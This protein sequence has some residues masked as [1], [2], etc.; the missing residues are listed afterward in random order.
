VA[1]IQTEDD[2]SQVRRNGWRQGSVVSPEL[3]SVLRRRGFSP[4]SD[5][6]IALVLSHDCDVVNGRF[7]KEPLV[8]LAW[9]TRIEKPDGRNTRGKNPRCLH[10]PLRQADGRELWWE[11]TAPC[12]FTEDRRLLL[13]SRPSADLTLPARD[14]RVVASWLAKRHDRS[15]FPDGFNRRL[16]TKG[17]KG[18][19]ETGSAYISELYLWGAD[20][21]LAEGEPYEILLCAVMTVEDFGDPEHRTAAVHC[22]QELEALLDACPGIEVLEARLVSEAE[23]TLD[24]L[25]R[26][27]RWDF[28]WLSVVEGQE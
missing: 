18:A 19:L 25:R 4:P 7:S 1:E 8:E 12:R 27:R 5:D 6:C 21:E 26:L 22:L 14:K 15:A 23:F 9:L 11:L 10:L 2:A 13:S 20:D 24:D 28:D 3:V 17:L 16:P